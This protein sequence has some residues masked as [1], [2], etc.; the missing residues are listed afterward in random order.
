MLLLR[1]FIFYTDISKIVFQN[2]GGQQR[3]NC[4][5]RSKCN[6]EWIRCKLL[7]IVKVG[8]N[9]CCGLNYTELLKQD[10]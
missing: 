5:P 8:R 3:Q 2:T 4:K 9:V 10:C 6:T 7:S 1:M